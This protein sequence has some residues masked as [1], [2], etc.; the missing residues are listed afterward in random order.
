MKIKENEV[1]MRYLTRPDNK[2]KETPKEPA[3]TSE[4]QAAGQ[5]YT[6]NSDNNSWEL[7]TP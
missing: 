6:Y 5:Y 2:L 1:M 3:L 7:Q 4:Q